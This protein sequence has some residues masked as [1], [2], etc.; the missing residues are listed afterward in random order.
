MKSSFWN[1]WIFKMKNLNFR[2]HLRQDITSK[3]NWFEN[4]FSDCRFENVFSELLSLTIAFS[5]L[6]FWS[7]TCFFEFSWRLPLWKRFYGWHDEINRFYLLNLN[8]LQWKCFS[9]YTWAAPS[10]ASACRPYDNVQGI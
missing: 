3:W 5:W 7:F 10:G 1:V 6:S 4:I 8:F 9:A 2:L